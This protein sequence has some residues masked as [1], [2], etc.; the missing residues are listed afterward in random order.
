MDQIK[1]YVCSPHFGKFIIEALQ[2]ISELTPITTVDNP[3]T[4]DLIIAEDDE[5]LRSFGDKG[6]KCLK[7][8]PTASSNRLSVFEEIPVDVIVPKLIS[9]IR[10]LQK[11]L[12]S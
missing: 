10:K 7:I 8:V 12:T 5:V 1:V 9:Q 2:K 11:T 3:S 6:T 4:A